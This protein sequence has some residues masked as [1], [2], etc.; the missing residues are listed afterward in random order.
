M[1]KAHLDMAARVRL[2]RGLGPATDDEAGG[3]VSECTK[4][5]YENAT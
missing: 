4:C 1:S 3:Q 2:G 5:E